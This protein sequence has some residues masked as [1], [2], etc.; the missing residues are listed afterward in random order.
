MLNVG[1][2]EVRLYFVLDLIKKTIFSIISLRFLVPFSIYLASD[3][4]IFLA[5]KSTVNYGAVK[6]WKIQWRKIKHPDDGIKTEI[7]SPDLFSYIPKDMKAYKDYEFRILGTLSDSWFD[8][9]DDIAP[10]TPGDKAE[11]L[12][13]VL[14]PEIDT[15]K[16]P[17]LKNE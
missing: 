14:H 12:P 5:W 17:P 6:H 7:I 11:P 4:T 8:K 16:N 9:E 3:N 15:K 10:W 13:K 2:K 1:V